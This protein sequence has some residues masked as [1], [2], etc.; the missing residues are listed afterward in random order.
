MVKDI[1]EEDEMEIKELGADF[2]IEKPMNPQ[3]IN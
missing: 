2:V 1:E 3:S